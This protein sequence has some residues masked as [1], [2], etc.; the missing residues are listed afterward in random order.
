MDEQSHSRIPM[1]C[2][3]YEWRLRQLTKSLDMSPEDV[4]T[5]LAMRGISI[6][7]AETIRLINQT[8]DA[9]PLNVVAAL[10]DILS[11]NVNALILVGARAIAVGSATSSRQANASSRDGGVTEDS[12]PTLLMRQ[13]LRKLAATSP[14]V[15]ERSVLQKLLREVR[16]KWGEK[17]KQSFRADIRASPDALE[18]AISEL[19]M[20]GKCV[21]A[22]LSA[23]AVKDDGV[24]L[25]DSY[26]RDREPPPK[27]PHYRLGRPPSYRG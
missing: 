15:I 1:R 3:A 14:E 9:V 24:A 18:W 23:K 5:A 21:S 4:S 26:R 2:V 17:W 6:D 25:L 22:P 12:P 11:C 7:R 19:E 8:P 20:L 27:A 13:A 10:C 16:G